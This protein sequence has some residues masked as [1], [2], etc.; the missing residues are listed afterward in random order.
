MQNMAAQFFRYYKEKNKVV[1]LYIYFE[2]EIHEKLWIKINQK[3]KTA[4]VNIIK[5]DY[6]GNLGHFCWLIFKKTL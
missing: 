6:W 1:Q 5:I 2:L 3:I 4:L